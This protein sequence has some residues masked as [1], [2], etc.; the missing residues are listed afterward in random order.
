MVFTGRSLPPPSAWTSFFRLLQALTDGCTN[1]TTKH[2]GTSDVSL[3]LAIWDIYAASTC[4]YHVNICGYVP[5]PPSGI[6][7]VSGF[8]LW[9]IDRYICMAVNVDRL[10][11]GTSLSLALSCQPMPDAKF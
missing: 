6:C 3:L 11:T 8:M 4:N 2:A 1:I 7:W 5:W 9:N 10:L